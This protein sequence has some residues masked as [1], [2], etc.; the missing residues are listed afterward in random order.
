MLIKPFD[1]EKVR[2][3]FNSAQPFRWFEVS[4]FLD[5]SFARDVVNAYPTFETAQKLGFEFKAVNEQKKVQI[6]D[7]AKFPGAVKRLSDAL[8]SPE[9]L[10]DLEYITGIPRL[11]ADEKLD[12]GGMH[13]TGPGGRLDVHVDFNYLQSQQMHRRLNILVYLNPEWSEAWG[14]N[15]ELWDREVKNRAQSFTPMLN[16]CVVFETNDI[17]YHGVSPVQCPA[18]IARRSFAAY[19]YT[20]E[21]PAGWQGEMHSTIF[22]A[23]PGERLRGYVLMPLETVQRRVRHGVERVARRVK[24]ILEQ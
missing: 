7:S 8:A 18:D 21:A 17:S 24:K 6:T 9:W 14:G 11:L 22:R 1:R 16:R 3:Q 19:Y 12:G 23:R 15:I 20:R 10:K 13:L 2:Q 4:P 5:E